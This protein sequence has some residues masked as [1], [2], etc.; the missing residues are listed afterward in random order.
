[1]ARETR[2]IRIFAV[3]ACVAIAAVSM[4]SGWGYANFPIYATG[5]G[6]SVSTLA[7][8]YWAP[9][10]ATAVLAYFFLPVCAGARERPVC[11]NIS[12]V[13]VCVCV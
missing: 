7:V 2:G 1:M 4:V 11:V 3:L 8:M 5:L 12:V 10:W 13:H 6:L 9:A